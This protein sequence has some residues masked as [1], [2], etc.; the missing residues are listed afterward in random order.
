MKLKREKQ[1]RKLMGY[2]KLNFGFREPYQVLLDEEIL[3]D[4]VST[5][6]DIVAGLD[7]TLQG[8][9]KPM[10]TQCTV[11]HLYRAK[12]PEAKEAIKIAKTFERRRCGHVQREKPAE[13]DAAPA[14]TEAAESAAPA[15][16]KSTE[17]PTPLSAFECL[18]DVV[19]PTNKHR[20]CVAT[21]KPKLRQ[22][23]RQIPGVPLIYLNRS[24]IIM[25]PMSK[26]TQTMRS[27]IEQ[28]KLVRGL[29]DAHTD[30]PETGPR[31]PKKVKGPNP[32]SVKKRQ[33]E[34]EQDGSGKKRRR[35]K[36]GHGHADTPHLEEADHSQSPDESS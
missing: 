14:E 35:G 3:L 25:E 7:R 16:R 19:G 10:V 9:V 8:K 5:K 32:L 12:T 11:E 34:P 28:S 21:Q 31:K 15:Q 1:Y 36:R 33:R 4:A 24:V 18:S 2:L 23:F 29:N 20:Y 22:K 6:F 13:N 30:E 17:N 27:D 26:A